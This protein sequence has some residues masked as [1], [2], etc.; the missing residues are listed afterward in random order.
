MDAVTAGAGSSLGGKSAAPAASSGSLVGV[1][2]AHAAV[3][4]LRSAMTAAMSA[5][6]WE[7]EMVTAVPPQRKEVKRTRRSM[8]AFV[9]VWLSVEG[10]RH[11]RVWKFGALRM[12]ERE[13]LVWDWMK[14]APTSLQWRVVALW[15]FPARG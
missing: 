15:R 1:S 11:W 3:Q 8:A 9:E 4:V 2:P 12:S 13:V 5:I 14:R 6:L 10:R 7:R